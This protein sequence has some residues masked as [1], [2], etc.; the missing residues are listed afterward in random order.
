MIVRALNSSHD[1]TFGKGQNNYLS[2]NAATVQ[3]INTRLNSFLGDC[4]F[5]LGAGVNW[6][7]FIGS[8]NI[9]GLNLSIAA[10]ILNTSDYQGNQL[11][12]YINQLY[13]TLT[14]QRALSIAYNVQTVYS[15]V[16]D[17]ITVSI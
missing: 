4:F 5:D 16:S 8:K 1:W 15:T 2:G 17:E 11:V 12:Q 10:V 14:S 6:F 9:V 3:L 7:N 13:V